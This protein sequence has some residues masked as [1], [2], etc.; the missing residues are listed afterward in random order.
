VHLG[1]SILRILGRGLRNS[2]SRNDAPTAAAHPRRQVGAI[3]HSAAGGAERPAKRG[4]YPGRG[5]ESDTFRRRPAS[6]IPVGFPRAGSPYTIAE[7][8]LPSV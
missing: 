1:R 2:G 5:S 6:G 7:A 8:G 3:Q 4:T